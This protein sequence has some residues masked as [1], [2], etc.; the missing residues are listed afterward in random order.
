MSRGLPA[1]HEP[2][3]FKEFYGPRLH[4]YFAIFA[5]LSDYRSSR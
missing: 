5:S 1:T 2:L 3:N 4:R